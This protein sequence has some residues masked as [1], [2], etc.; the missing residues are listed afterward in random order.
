VVGRQGGRE[1]RR[2]KR[3]AAGKEAPAEPA[4]AGA[5]KRRPNRRRPAKEA[6]A[7]LSAAAG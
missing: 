7:E 1:E 3:A 4:A 5:R 6:P 2:A